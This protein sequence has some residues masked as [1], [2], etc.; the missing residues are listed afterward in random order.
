MQY[1][2]PDCR[3]LLRNLLCMIYTKPHDL[4]TIG[5]WAPRL[6]VVKHYL[7]VGFRVTF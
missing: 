4:L 2:N 6:I 7:S 1:L 3:I 5:S